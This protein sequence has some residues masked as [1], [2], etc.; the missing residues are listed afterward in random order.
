MTW[1]EADRYRRLGVSGD[2]LTLIGP[3][4]SPP[5]PPPDRE[6]VRRELGLPPGSRFIIAAGKLEPASGLKSAIWTFDI[7]RYEAPDLHLVLVGDGPDRWALEEFGR[8]I[9]FDDFRV[10]F[11]G[12]RP[13]LPALLGLAE[14]VWVTRDRGGVNLALEAMAAGRPVG[15]WRTPELAEVVEDGVTGFLA[16]PGERAQLSAKTYPLVHEPGLAARLGAAGKALS[17]ERFGVGRAVEQWE[18]L[19]RELT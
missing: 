7:L 6:A 17:A 18:Q 14:V 2:H 1:A 12:H 9:A 19:Y 4:V 13:D 3:C 16:D 10:R 5:G 11:A 8:A 15:G